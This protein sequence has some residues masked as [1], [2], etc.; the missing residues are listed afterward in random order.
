M[1]ILLSM[2]LGEGSTGLSSFEHVLMECLIAAVK[3]PWHDL[4]LHDECLSL[5]KPS[6]EKKL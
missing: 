6:S 3:I 5:A 1:K 2:E 4:Q